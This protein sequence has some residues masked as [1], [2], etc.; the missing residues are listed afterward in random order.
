MTDFADL[1]DVRGRTYAET[2]KAHL[3][4]IDAL[5]VGKTAPDVEGEDLDAAALKL[6]DFRGRVVLV[7][8]WGNWCGPCRALLPHER[9]L[10]KKLAGRPFTLLGVNSDEDRTMAKKA[11]LKE[12][13]TWCSFWNGGGTDG[14]I[15]TKWNVQGWPTLYVIDA[16]GVIRHKWLGSPGDKVLNES[17]EALVKEA[18]E[19]K[20]PK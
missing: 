3:Y 12:K 11:V 16:R 4:E 6:S 17:V 7:N 20:T 9:A 1:K 10:V 8:F 5:S 18:E 14:P 2:A 19:V 15:S 13:L